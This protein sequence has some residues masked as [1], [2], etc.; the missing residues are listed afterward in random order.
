[1]RAIYK[2]QKACVSALF[3]SSRKKVMRRRPEKMWSTLSAA[4]QTRT[5]RRDSRLHMLILLMYRQQS[6]EG[7]TSRDRRIAFGQVR[8]QKTWRHQTRASRTGVRTEAVPRHEIQNEVTI[9]GVAW[10]CE[11]EKERAPSAHTTG[12]AADFRLAN[13]DIQSRRRYSRVRAD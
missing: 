3:V 7:L 4:W 8:T 12:L 10:R 11:K 5:S 13:K 2:N 1:M 6:Y 9:A